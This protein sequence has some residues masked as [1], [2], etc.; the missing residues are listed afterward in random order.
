MSKGPIPK[1]APR[2]RLIGRKEMKKKKRKEEIK[3]TKEKRKKKRKKERKKEK[4]KKTLFKY[5]DVDS[6]RS[7]P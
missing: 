2:D 3:K 4:K 5:P 6:I 7:T 1:G